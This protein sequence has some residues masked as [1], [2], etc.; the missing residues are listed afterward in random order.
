MMRRLRINQHS[1]RHRK[2]R[3][4]SLI[5]Q[6]GNADRPSYPNGATENLRRQIRKAGQLTGA[7]GENDLSARFGGERRAKKPAAD[8]LQYFLDPW[9]DEAH[10][11]CARNELRS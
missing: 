9:F 7:T 3:T 2:R 8:G 1:C 5:R 6:S 4:L 10:Q 11:T